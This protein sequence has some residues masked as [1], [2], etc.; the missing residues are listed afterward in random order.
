MTK[1]TV[2][3][4]ASFVRT[5]SPKSGETII[6]H[7]DKGRGEKMLEGKAQIK[8]TDMP[9]KM[10]IQAMTSASEARDIYDVTDCTSIAAH[11]K[12]VR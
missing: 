9:R 1:W 6:S 8:E 2:W 11:I 7:I 10:Q 3:I 12:K 5:E 4:L